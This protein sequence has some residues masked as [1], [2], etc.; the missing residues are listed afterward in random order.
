MLNHSEESAGRD[1]LEKLS[2]LIRLKTESFTDYSL[3]DRQAF[4]AVEP[5]LKELF[6]SA[7]GVLETLISEDLALLYRWK[8]SDPGLEPDLYLAH[9]DVVGAGESGW[10]HPPFEGVI[11][12]DVLY[13]RGCL[14]C[15]GP[16]AALLE[17]VD[18]LASGGYRP[19]R[20]LYFAF[21]GDE[22]VAGLRGAGMMARSLADRGL[23][24]RYILDEGG[25][26][27]RGMLNPLLKNPVA[28][29]GVAEKGMGSL[30]LSCAGET[31]HSSSPPVHTAIG[32]LSKAV[33][34]LEKHPYPAR[35]NPVV[36]RFLK[37]LT[38][39]ARGPMKALLLALPLTG[40]L[41]VKAFAAS[42]ATAPLVRTTQAVTLISGGTRENVLPGSAEAVVN[43]RILPGDTMASIKARAETLLRGT[44]VTVEEF[45]GWPSNDPVL[46]SSEDPAVTE[47]FLQFIEECFPGTVAAPYLM[48]ASTDS[49]FYRDL[50]PRILRF[51][52]FKTD[53]ELLKTV[54]GVNERISRD[55]FQGMVR[56]YRTVL[57]KF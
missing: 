38:P 50:A 17:A 45:D 31:G 16:L 14:D 34:I 27:T 18:Q 26:V 23:H 11:D 15:K 37:T 44:G 6:P 12:G 28:L 42:G 55:D 4:T 22:E 51:A 8:G 48:T 41:L 47:R 9:F 10:T 2:R 3:Y 30:K 19:E 7:L 52:P 54:H 49:K 33:T 53:A 5:L 29:V 21:G 40:P 35:L 43:Y 24:F 39:H 46:E 1:P 32:H 36:L 56:F 13:G 57:E 25:A 20:D